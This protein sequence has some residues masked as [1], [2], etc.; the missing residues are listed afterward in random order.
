MGVLITTVLRYVNARLDAFHDMEVVKITGR[1]CISGSVLML[2]PVK[3]ASKIR[4]TGL[5][6]WWRAHGGGHEGVA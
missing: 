3:K 2:P 5:W 6:L 4:Q 1:R